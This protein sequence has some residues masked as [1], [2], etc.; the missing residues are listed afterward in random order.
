MCPKCKKLIDYTATYCERCQKVHDEEKADFRKKAN[1]KYNKNRD[2]KYVKFRKSS[3]WIALKNK[4]LSDLQKKYGNNPKYAYKC[5]DC[6]EMNNKNPE[7]KIAIAEEVH[8]LV[9]I[10]T[11]E[12]WERRLDYYNLRALCHFHH[13][14]RHGRFQ[15]K[16]KLN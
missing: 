13:D 5:E 3:E 2:P 4:Y 10:E 7:W 1:I 14:M 6:I 11:P 8:H 9:F 16:K 15:R 12:G